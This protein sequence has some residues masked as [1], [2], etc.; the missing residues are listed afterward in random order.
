MTAIQ[1]VDRLA[2]SLADFTRI[3][4]RGTRARFRDKIVAPIKKDAWAGVP[5]SANASRGKPALQFNPTTSSI[6]MRLGR[7]SASCPC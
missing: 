6:T 1:K 7:G 3:E 5:G 4:R 2:Q